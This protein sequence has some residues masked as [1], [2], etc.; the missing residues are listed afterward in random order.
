MA[1]PDAPR[2]LF[3]HAKR[4]A[5]VVVIVWALALVWSLGY[6][7]LRGYRPAD[8]P[9]NDLTL[10][11]GF[12]DWIFYGIMLPWVACSLFTIWFGL[13]GMSDDDLGAEKDEEGH[14]HGH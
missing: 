6:C 1:D 10:I 8:D 7:Y 14:G 12:P 2:R 4:E 13:Y 5:L 9:G 3:R 11:L